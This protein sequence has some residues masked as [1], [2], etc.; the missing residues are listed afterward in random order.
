MMTIIDDARGNLVS[1]LEEL[2]DRIVEGQAHFLG[3]DLQEFKDRLT[4]MATRG[5]PRRNLDNMMKVDV[6][7]SVSTA[8][9]Q[10][11]GGMPEPLYRYEFLPGHA[12]PETGALPPRAF[13]GRLFD[14]VLDSVTDDENYRNKVTFDKNVF[15][16]FIAVM[17][18]NY[19]TTDPMFY[20]TSREDYGVS[21]D[22]DMNDT[23][24]YQA[25][26]R[27]LRQLERGIEYSSISGAPAFTTPTAMPPAAPA[28]EDLSSLFRADGGEDYLS[29]LPHAGRTIEI[30]FGAPEQMLL[31][32]LALLADA[33]R[34]LKHMDHPRAAELR[35]MIANSGQELFRGLQE[36]QILS[37]LASDPITD[38]LED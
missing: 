25:V 1:R 15:Q 4:H 13:I 6:F 18:V 17:F 9:A 7:E 21:S 3:T 8:D 23:P 22:K 35:A 38:A 20:G 29:S 24:L 19:A 12:G 10:L 32:P 27:A 2:R 16:K 11:T 14:D 5:A 31:E 33:I 36:L 30:P 28:A 26:A 34:L 37:P